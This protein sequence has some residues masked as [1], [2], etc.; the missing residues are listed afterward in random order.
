MRG[1]RAGGLRGE[2]G[3]LESRS[4]CALCCGLESP[5]CCVGSCGCRGVA[6]R[7]REGRRLPYW[8]LCGGGRAVVVAA[9]RVTEPI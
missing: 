8:P 4:P 7:H 5:P 3:G 2:R 1:L 6:E 9:A